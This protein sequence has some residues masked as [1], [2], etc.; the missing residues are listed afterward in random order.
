MPSARRQPSKAAPKKPLPARTPI[1]ELGLT[2]AEAGRLTPGARKLTRGDLIAMM[3]G[4][5]PAAAQ[6]L[7]LRD[8]N[9][10]SQVY[11]AGARAGFVGRPNPGCCCCCSGRS[12][13]CCCCCADP[14][15][16]ASAA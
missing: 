6:A 13:C 5:I 4:K 8:L 1:A 2:R 11:T 3:E 9:S 10:I 7:T 16:I 14:G 12:G 15:R